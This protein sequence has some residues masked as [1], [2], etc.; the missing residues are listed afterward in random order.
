MIIFIT[1]GTGTIGTALIENLI[2]NPSIKQIISFSK[3]E[4]RIYKSKNNFNSDKVK[5]V[6]GDVSNLEA[7]TV[8]TAGA[9]VILHLAAM[10]HV[11]LAEENP[12][13]AA[14]TNVLGT[15]NVIAAAKLN[16][17]KKL[18]F[19]ST[20]KASI[21]TEV[22]AATK[23]LS[24]KIVIASSTDD[25]KM[26]VVRF[27]NVIGSSGS[28][29]LKWKNQIAK[30]EQLSVTDK[31]ANRFFIIAA[32]AAKF[33]IKMIDEANGKEIFIPKMK[34]YNIYDLAAN[35]PGN[36]QGV[37]V[38]GLRPGERF[39]E[40]LVSSQET[41]VLVD[42]DDHY[43]ILPGKQQMLS[44]ASNDPEYLSPAKDFFDRYYSL[45]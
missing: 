44:I 14:K 36:K 18:I 39:D 33:I 23:S 1:G 40:M 28:V 34:S 12:I 35:F 15:S 16:K 5:Y 43:C 10:K 2:E 17:V 41:G 22:Y 26:S 8:A 7:L 6:V 27:G 13:E 20:D 42:K 25:F 19:V 30:E 4:D 9:D 3:G 11:D 24:E 45:I 29:F 32:D 38:I 21:P 31:Q 37:G